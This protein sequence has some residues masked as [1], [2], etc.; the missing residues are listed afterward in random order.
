MEMPNNGCRTKNYRISSFLQN[1]QAFD[2][3]IKIGSIFLCLYQYLQLQ[4]IISVKT[5]FPYLPPDEISL[6]SPSLIVPWLMAWHAT[7]E[8]PLPFCHVVLL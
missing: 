4:K 5:A 3:G 6:E 7:I 2:R 8:Q 1:S